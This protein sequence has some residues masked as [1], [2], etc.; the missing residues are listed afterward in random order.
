MIGTRVITKEPKGKEIND[1]DSFKFNAEFTNKLY[2]IK[3]NSIQV[4]RYIRLQNLLSVL[5]GFLCFF[6]FCS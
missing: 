5:Y 1:S 4:R 2:H 6:I 3:I